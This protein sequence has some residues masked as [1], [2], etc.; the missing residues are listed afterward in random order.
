MTQETP[1]IPELGQLLLSNSE[2]EAL[3][4]QSF[5]SRGL[6]DLGEL[7]R[8][9]WLCDV[10]YHDHGGNPAGFEGGDFECETFA[11][12]AY[13]WCDGEEHPGGCPPNF[14]HFA[15]GFTARWYKHLGRG[16]S[17]NR[18][19]TQSEW[20]P[21]RAECL[22]EILAAP[23]IPEDERMWH[24]EWDNTADTSIT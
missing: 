5:V 3:E 13:C 4:I 10:G 1:Y 14:E 18:S 19:L 24:Q 12:R 20:E 16:A 17:Q 22:N 15:S 6:R 2:T 11:L 7:I 8:D 21:I 23:P 9:R